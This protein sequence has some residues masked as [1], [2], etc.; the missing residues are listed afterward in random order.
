MGVALD[1]TVGD[2][3]FPLAGRI[4]SM[5][6][7]ARPSARASRDK[8]VHVALLRGVNLGGRRLPMKD[9][10]AMFRDAGCGDVR[11]YI[12][13]GNVVF[14][15]RPALARQVPAL[16]SEAI[17]DRF[18]FEAPIVTRTAAEME[19][20]AS[21]NP[22]L[23]AGADPKT[24]HVVFLQD[25]PSKARVAELDPGRSP[26]DEFAVQGREVYLHCPNGVGSS[27]LTMPYFDSK[28]QTIATARNWNTVLK[29]VEMS[30]GD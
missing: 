29:L 13:S 5:K 27:K 24:L 14:E 18:G 4:R 20:V 8:P 23:K 6:K 21:H 19:D 16:V 15:A 22:F 10:A 30:H 28:L 3:R 25:R 2:Q 26:P 7:Q 1:A 17:T 11:T 12:Q 9:L